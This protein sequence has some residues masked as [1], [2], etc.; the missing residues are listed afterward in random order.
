M[1]NWAKFEAMP[2]CQFGV[3]SKYAALSGYVVN[4]GCP[5]EY[6]VWWGNESDC[7][8]VC[9]VHA[10]AIEE[11]E[12]DEKNTAGTEAEDYARY[13]NEVA[14]ARQ[15]AELEQ[16]EM[17]QAKAQGYANADKAAQGQAG[18]PPY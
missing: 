13:E 17:A 1:G 5:A 18:L 15:Q 6:K 7:M 12:T 10:E 2:E 8:Y 14:A 11:S 4:C 16:E 9:K 3:Y